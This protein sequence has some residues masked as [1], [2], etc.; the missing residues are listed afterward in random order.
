ML[1][2]ACGGSGSSSGSGPRYDSFDEMVDAAE[3]LDATVFPIPYTDPATL[4]RSGTATH[5]GLLGV[6]L[7]DGSTAVGEMTLRTS[8]A[9][10]TI[11]GDVEN[12]RGDDDTEFAGSLDISNGQIDRTADVD[13]G[14]TFGADLDGRLTAEGSTFDVDARLQGD[15]TGARYQY[16]EGFVDGTVAV[17]GQALRISQGSFAGERR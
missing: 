5:D 14:F 3:A 17:D 11:S 12:V 7:T 13:T 6:A 15:Y 2:T 9:G 1:L 8:F 10:G 16:V 4:P